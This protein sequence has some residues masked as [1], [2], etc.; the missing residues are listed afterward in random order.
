MSR[1]TDHFQ[2]RLNELID[3]FRKEYKLTYSEAVGCLFMKAHELTDE[4]N[5]NDQDGE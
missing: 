5:G 4:A 2:E 3:Y 1:A